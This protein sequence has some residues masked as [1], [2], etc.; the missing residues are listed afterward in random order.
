MS[1]IEI[2]D[3][4]LNSESGLKIVVPSRCRLPQSHSLAWIQTP[5]TQ[6]SN[7]S[8]VIGLVLLG[9]IALLLLA[10]CVSGGCGF[11]DYLDMSAAFAIGLFLRL[12]APDVSD[13]GF[14]VFLANAHNGLLA[15]FSKKLSDVDRRSCDAV[16][17]LFCLLRRLRTFFVGFVKSV[18]ILSTVGDGV[19]LIS[20]YWRQFRDS[21]AQ[22]SQ[23]IPQQVRQS[24][25][26]LLPDSPTAGSTESP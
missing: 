7:G 5:I 18:V 22:S 2:N 3:L 24:Y 21:E 26:E 16:V 13:C 4:H 10:Q 11:R 14:I 19:L 1:S 25:A 23:A 12:V 8:I 17:T 20:C 9:S 15:P 6:P